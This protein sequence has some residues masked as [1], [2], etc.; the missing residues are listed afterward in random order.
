M[1]TLPK[2][3][4]DRLSDLWEN[5]SSVAI[6]VYGKAG[7]AEF[8]NPAMMFFLDMAES[9]SSATNDFINPPLTQLIEKEGDGLVFSGFIT[10]GNR[11]DISYSLESNVYKSE[12]I[13]LIIASAD[14]GHLFS[15]NA[16]MSR[17]NQKVSNLQRDLMLEQIK[18]KNTLNVLRETQGLLVHSEKMNAMGQLVAGIA[19]EINNPLSFVYSNLHSLKSSIKQYQSAL[20]LLENLLLNREET[21]LSAQVAHIREEKDLDFLNEDMILMADESLEGLKR[22]KEIV[23]NLREYSR[24]DRA[25]KDH[26]D[27]IQC[28][29]STVNILK[30]EL[31]ERSI[32][33]TLDGPE[34]L[35]LDFY[36]AQFNQVIMNLLM[37]AIQ[38]IDRNGII[39]ISITKDMEEV[40]ISVRDSGPGIP[41]EIRSKI[42]DPFFTT[43]E[44]GMGVGI[45][46]SI[47]YRIIHN[48][49]KGQLILDKDDTNGACFIISIPYTQKD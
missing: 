31:R 19:H 9:G 4:Q 12:G 48:L 13:T 15:E 5:S 1:I 25:E 29:S 17:L 36:P 2:N 23:E 32:D 33:F 18:L 47:S 42:F 40:R 39:N 6:A 20:G 11:A 43:K 41:E 24:L 28:I 45:G 44:I 7:Q 34:T 49:H 37:N 16:K 3:I 22:V 27:L 26:S 30:P 14:T 38:A 21:A 46:L 10:I 8:L 35:F